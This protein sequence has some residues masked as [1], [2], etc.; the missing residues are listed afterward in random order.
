MPNK[1]VSVQT[2]TIVSNMDLQRKI[3]AE[4]M[5]R[6]NPMRPVSIFKIMCVSFLAVSLTACGE[7]PIDIANMSKGITAEL[8]AGGATS[9]SSQINPVDVSKG[10]QSAL[11]SAVTMNEGYRAAMALEEAAK[12]RILV[13]SSARRA[14]VSSNANVGAIGP[15]GS[16]TASG[17]A[18]I[19]GGVTLSQLV[20]DGGESA[21]TTNIATAEALGAQADRMVQGNTVAL[22]AAR[23]WIDFWQ[24]SERL[25]LLA[26][27]RAEMETLIAQMERMEQNGMIGRSAL[28]SARSQAMDFT[29]EELQL[30]T[31]L[32]EAKSQ[33][34]HYYKQNPNNISPPEQVIKYAAAHEVAAGWRQSPS[35][36]RS[37]SAVLIAQQSLAVAESNFRP[38]ARI[39][40]GLTTPLKSDQSSDASIG[41]VFNYTFTDGGRRKAQLNAAKSQLDSTQAAL[42]EAQHLLET[43][44][45]VAMSRL[46]ALEKSMPLID[47][48]IRLSETEIDTA[49]S[50][51]ATGQSDL[52][53]LIDTKIRNFRAR[54]QMV[55]MKAEYDLLL[56]VIGSRTGELSRKLGL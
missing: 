17:D 2:L 33:F 56:L 46:K 49:Q 14:Q 40:A 48:K 10:F 32:D 20:F 3:P 1:L 11:R 41:L 7:K 25:N 22:A 38:R 15:I 9:P 54:D 53:Q 42:N 39:Q 44:L 35:L 5:N 13:A 37:A 8:A 52:R 51:I 43:E 50:E 30:K 16:S 21:A 34:E 12:S 29:L 18:G 47:E 23:A 6:F 4:P 55:T 26:S 19:A 28:D 27:R 24:F 45:N 31:S 36:Q